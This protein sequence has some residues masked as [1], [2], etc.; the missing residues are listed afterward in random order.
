MQIFALG[1]GVQPVGDRPVFY[2]DRAAGPGRHTGMDNEGRS[3]RTPPPLQLTIVDDEGMSPEVALV[4]TPPR[5]TEGLVSTVTAV[6]SGPLDAAATITVSASPSP[7]AGSSTGRRGIALS[8]AGSLDEITPT[9]LGWKIMRIT[10]GMALLLLL[11]AAGCGGDDDGVVNPLA[12]SGIAPADTASGQSDASSAQVAQ[13]D[14]TSMTNGMRS[15]TAAKN[16][17]DFSGVSWSWNAKNTHLEPDS[18]PD[19]R[20]QAGSNVW[21]R[22]SGTGLIRIFSDA[23]LDGMTF[24]TAAGSW[25]LSMRRAGLYVSGITGAEVDQISSGGGGG[26]GGGGNEPRNGPRNGPRSS[27]LQCWPSDTSRA[28]RL[29]AESAYAGTVSFV[30]TITCNRAVDGSDG[31]NRTRDAAATP[32]HFYAAVPASGSPPWGQ[33]TTEVTW[34]TK[35]PASIAVNNTASAPNYS[36]SVGFSFQR[37]ETGSLRAGHLVWDAVVP[38]GVTKP[39]LTARLVQQAPAD[40]ECT[41]PTVRSF[42]ARAVDPRHNRITWSLPGQSSTCEYT[43]LQLDV[44]TPSRSSVVQISPPVV[45]GQPGDLTTTEYIHGALPTCPEERCGALTDDEA[46]VTYKIR[47]TDFGNDNAGAWSRAVTV[48]R[49]TVVTPTAPLY[50]RARHSD[51]G[52]VDLYWDKPAFPEDEAGVTYSFQA[53]ARGG[54]WRN[55]TAFTSNGAKHR[56]ASFADMPPVG[57]ATEYRFRVRATH[58]GR[59]GPWSDATNP[60]TTWNAPERVDIRIGTVYAGNVISAGKVNLVF[61]WNGADSHLRNSYDDGHANGVAFARCEIS[62]GN[63]SSYQLATGITGLDCLTYLA[64]G[65]S[66]NQFSGLTLSW[67][68]TGLPVDQ[69]IWLRFSLRRGTITGPTQ[70]VDITRNASNQIVSRNADPPRGSGPADPC[71]NGMCNQPPDPPW[72][73]ATYGAGYLT[74]RWT[75]TTDARYF[76]G[77]N[78]SGNPATIRRIEMKYEACPHYWNTGR[79][80]FERIGPAF[81]ED[82]TNCTAGTGTGSATGSITFRGSFGVID[83]MQVDMWE[84][85]MNAMVVNNLGRPSPWAGWTGGHVTQD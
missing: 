12:P 24:S 5:V 65:G 25:P 54:S 11:T 17:I 37:N 77:T 33:G 36:V 85:K 76:P 44:A 28:P 58:N 40:I 74:M 52:H 7:L 10:T 64:S 46:T 70:E 72:S 63:R 81:G 9:A 32:A 71:S 39:T 57:R 14:L 48:Q 51:T 66:G 23:D 15:A 62:V 31:Q 19:A 69:A 34:V 30:I 6:A 27:H 29:A 1:G 41:L 49:S 56:R 80:R 50:L 21:R 22:D 42:S 3:I 26:G 79:R 60:A 73:E 75:T 18:L 4:L 43:A 67:S 78:S 83:G 59:S 82:D 68:S 16:T 45:A 2:T 47:T 8:A 20:V 38:S 61:G 13:G 84:A 35:T 55:F 53:S